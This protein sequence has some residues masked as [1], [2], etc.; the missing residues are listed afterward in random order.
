MENSID[1]GCLLASY[2]CSKDLIEKHKLFFMFKDHMNLRVGG[3]KNHTHEEATCLMEKCFPGID[4]TVVTLEEIVTF[5]SSELG[6]AEEKQRD[7][8]NSLRDVV[9]G[10]VEKIGI[11]VLPYS[12]VA[13]R[14]I[15]LLGNECVDVRAAALRNLE[16]IVPGGL[17]E[18][19]Y[20]IEK[21]AIS[22]I[23]NTLT[24]KNQKLASVFLTLIENILEVVEQN[25]GPIRER[26][27]CKL[28]DQEFVPKHLCIADVAIQK[29]VVKTNFQ[30]A[31]RR[32]FDKIVSLD[33]EEAIDSRRKVLEDF[34]VYNSRIEDATIAQMLDIDS[35]LK[36]VQVW[37]TRFLDCQRQLLTWG[38]LESNIAFNSIELDSLSMKFNSTLSLP[39]HNARDNYL[40]KF[41]SCNL[42]GSIISSVDKSCLLTYTSLD[43]KCKD[44]DFLH[45]HSGDRTRCGYFS[46]NVIDKHL[47][48]WISIPTKQHSLLNSHR[49][50]S[51]KIPIKIIKSIKLNLFIILQQLK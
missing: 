8:D 38:K 30:I 33:P 36:N 41:F 23:D 7:R 22:G 20:M 35:D 1:W 12:D 3:Y 6:A 26:I 9:V 5:S 45:V 19:V 27:M 44:L 31:S 32:K 47:V 49:Y 34:K 28:S 15:D 40:K 11:S 42:H 48:D 4:T 17:E 37:D 13:V 46:E 10:V 18:L 43:N 50:E 24:A 14:L 25:P 21:G 16:N 29:Q 51:V 2:N 39:Y